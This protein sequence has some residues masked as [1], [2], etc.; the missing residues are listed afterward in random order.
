MNCDLC[1]K[2]RACQQN[3]RDKCYLCGKTGVSLMVQED[4]YFCGKCNAIHTKQYL[5]KKRMEEHRDQA[6]RADCPS[7]NTDFGG[8]V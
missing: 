8:G 4:H 6:K 7:G 5:F 2:E 3:V 1:G